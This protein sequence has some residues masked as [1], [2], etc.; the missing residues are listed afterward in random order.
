MA[1]FWEIAAHSVDHYMFS[2]YFAYLY[3]SY[4]PFGFEGWNWVMIATVPDLCI[5]FTLN[6]TTIEIVF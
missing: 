5:L 6:K 2:L 3:F 4:F 1:T